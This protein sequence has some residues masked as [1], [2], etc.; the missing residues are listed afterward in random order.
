MDLKEGFFQA[1]GLADEGTAFV[2]KQIGMM[3]G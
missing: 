2:K 3:I 1:K